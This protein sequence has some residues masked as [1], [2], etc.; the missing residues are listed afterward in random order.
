MTRFHDLQVRQARFVA[1]LGDDQLA[2]IER[3][4]VRRALVRAVAIALPLK[5]RKSVGGDIDGVLE[6]RFIDPRGGAADRVQLVMR[7]GRCRGSR[8]GSARPDATATMRLADLVRLGAGAADGGWLAHD[9]RVVLSGDPFLF[10]RFPSA[11]GLR[12]R[13]LYAV[14][15]GP[16]LRD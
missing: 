4:L 12:T 14:P 7:N 13:P 2:F 5:F 1:G 3:G 10:V 11:F 6:L 15:R 16:N 8:G 9:G